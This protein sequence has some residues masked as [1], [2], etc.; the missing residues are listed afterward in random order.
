MKKLNMEY[1]ERFLLNAS[2]VFEDQKLKLCELD[3]AI[4]DGDHGTSI[5]L[6]FSGAAKYLFVEKPEDIGAL[7]QMIGKSFIDSVGGVT[8]IIFGTL[9]INLGKK[10]VNKKEIDISD[11]A[12]MFGSGLEMVK[13]RGKVKEGDKSIVDAL[14]PAVCA[15]EDASRN[16]LTSVEALILASQAADDGMEAT[17]EME[18]KVGRARYQKEK[19]KGHIDAGA[20]SLALIFK[21]LAETT[22]VSSG[23]SS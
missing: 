21:T 20:A 1:W 5:A 17:R 11:L 19:S 9:F 14:S 3:G 22:N 10:A 16:N 12:E 18:A 2:K 23:T 4:G 7:L 6:G 8:G 15:L 13:S